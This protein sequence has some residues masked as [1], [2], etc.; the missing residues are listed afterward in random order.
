[1]GQD[2]GASNFLKKLTN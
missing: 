2:I 1:M